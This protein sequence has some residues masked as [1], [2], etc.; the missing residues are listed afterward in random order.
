M[1]VLCGVMIH[2]AQ[3]EEAGVTSSETWR[4][5]MMPWFYG[6]WRF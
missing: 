1:E 5:F 2:L 6:T 4:F 3:E